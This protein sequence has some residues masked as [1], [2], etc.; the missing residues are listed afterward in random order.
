MLIMNNFS[1][2]HNVFKLSSVADASE[3][4]CMRERDKCVNRN[5]KKKKMVN[6]SLLKFLH[7][8][9]LR[10]KKKIQYF[11]RNVVVYIWARLCDM[12]RISSAVC[13]HLKM[14]NSRLR[15]TFW[16]VE[17]FANIAYSDNKVS[18]KYFKTFLVVNV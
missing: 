18:N 1:F 5:Y 15:S 16:N 6:I 11:H 12:G 2:C 3:N 4:V 10:R 17:T 9:S 13:Y 8:L 14:L 7:T